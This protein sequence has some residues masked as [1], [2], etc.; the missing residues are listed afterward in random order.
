VIAARGGLA[1]GTLEYQRPAV[2]ARP[3]RLLP[4]PAFLAGR[5]EMLARLH[6]WLAPPGSTAPRVAVLCGLG[7]C[8]KTS[9]A[10]EYAYRHR[11]E[12]GVVW[13]FQAEEPAALAAG[14]GDLGA[15]LGARSRPDAGDPVAQVH[16]ALAACPARWLL[17][18]DNTPDPLAIRHLLPPDG[19]GCVLVTSQHPHWPGSHVLEVPTL[20]TDTAAEF[21]RERHPRPP[22]QR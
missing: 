12:F 17:I 10:L 19:S 3:V 4:R 6:A 20:D 15:Q 1:I 14:F 22:S 11:G 8:G 5:E 18:F 21:L 13:Q 16:A 9:L 2:P 7:G